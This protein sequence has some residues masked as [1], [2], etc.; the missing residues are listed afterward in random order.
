ME[1]FDTLSTEYWR[2]FTA[3]EML[4]PLIMQF[5]K[6]GLEFPRIGLV[7][8]IQVYV[9][10]QALFKVYWCKK[11]I[12]SNYLIQYVEIEW[13]FVH[14]FYALKQFA[15]KRTSDSSI[16][17]EIGETGC[18]ESMTAAHNNS[19]DSLAN[20]EVQTTEVAQVKPSRFIWG[21]Y[22]WEFKLSR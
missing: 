1:I 13:Q 18:A 16:P 20:V 11:R 19:W 3:I 15:A 22:L 14:R 4:D 7:F 8:F 9:S 2:M 17:Q 6:I 12:I 21:V 5:A 10:L